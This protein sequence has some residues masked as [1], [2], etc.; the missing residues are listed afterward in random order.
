M[1]LGATICCKQQLSCTIRLAG[2]IVLRFSFHRS[3][4]EL[5]YFTHPGPFP[6]TLIPPQLVLPYW[7]ISEK[8]REARW[9]LAGV[10]ALTLATTGVR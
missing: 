1:L 4:A 8:A 7:T 6:Y 9:R 3:L 10:V 5:L 2:C